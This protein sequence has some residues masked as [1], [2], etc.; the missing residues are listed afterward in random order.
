MKRSVAIVLT[1]VIFAAIAVCFLRPAPSQIGHPQPFLAVGERL[2][3]SG[4]VEYFE[5]AEVLAVDYIYGTIDLKLPPVEPYTL[6]IGARV[7]E[8]GMAGEDEG[9]VEK[10]VDGEWVY[11]RET[12]LGGAWTLLGGPPSYFSLVPE[13][14]T[15]RSKYGQLYRLGAHKIL[16]EPGDYRFNL[17]FRQIENDSDEVGDVITISF[18]ITVPY[19][20]TDKKYDVYID[21]NWGGHIAIRSNDGSPA[22]YLFGDSIKVVDKESGEV[23]T[24]KTAS[25]EKPGTLDSPYIDYSVPQEKRTYRSFTFMTNW[26]YRLPRGEYQISLEFAENEDGSGT[27]YP[28]TYTTTLG[29]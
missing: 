2:E 23:V 25:W 4:D 5:Y 16:F 21:G 10:L 6:L 9:Y 15:V 3:L 24:G 14:S 28:F 22:P 8:Y 29:R 1:A 18:V 7:N 20:T 13:G 26:M 19:T 11:L 12:G 17:N 27:R